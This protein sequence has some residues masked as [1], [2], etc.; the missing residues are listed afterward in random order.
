MGD[1]RCLVMKLYKSTLQDVLLAHPRGAL[2]MG[3]G[4]DASLEM[5]RGLQ[6]MHDAGIV[7]LDLKPSNLLFDQYDSLFLADFGISRILPQGQAKFVPD[8]VSGT[9]NFMSPEQ[10]RPFESGGVGTASDVWSAACVILQVLSGEEPF[11]GM[12]HGEI[13]AQVCDQ[14]S[15]PPIPPG[16]SSDLS[17]VLQ[18]CF[19]HDP[20][21][22]PT[23]RELREALQACQFQVCSTPRI[24][25]AS[26]SFAPPSPVKPVSKTGPF[27]AAS[28]QQAPSSARSKRP[29]K[30][31]PPPPPQEAV[32]IDI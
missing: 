24:M 3:P 19:R 31:P 8:S 29:D 1:R 30:S 28:A 17:H 14:Q 25:E 27:I 18:T 16:I 2:G 22:R 20:S 12:Q 11:R 5:L 32:L 23:A 13:E 15:C 10:F 7:Y 26:A 9:P 4:I 21:Q 6:A